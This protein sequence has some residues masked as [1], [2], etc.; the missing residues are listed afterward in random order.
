MYSRT[1]FELRKSSNIHLNS[2]DLINRISKIYILKK[3][4]KLIFKY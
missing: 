4:M 2:K 3:M 1:W